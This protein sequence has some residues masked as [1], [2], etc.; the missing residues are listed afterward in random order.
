M[1]A[2]CI[3]CG[4]EIVWVGGLIREWLHVDEHEAKPAPGSERDDV[5]D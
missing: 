1:K 2:T 4:K 5:E 3:E